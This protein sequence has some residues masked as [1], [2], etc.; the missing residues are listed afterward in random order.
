MEDINKSTLIGVVFDLSESHEPNGIRTID[1]IKN[2]LCQK[3]LNE[4][5]QTKVF[6]SHPD[7]K[8]A[9]KDQGQSTFF[10][11]AY[12]EPNNFSIDECFRNAITVVG[13]SQDSDK[14]V[15]LFTDRF[16]SSINYQY[17]KSFIYKELRDYDIKIRVVGI[18]NTYHK[19]HL[20]EI[21]NS[22]NS[23][24]VHLNN[25]NELVNH[26]IELIEGK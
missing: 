5:N 14:I 4:N 26:I 8:S 11:V 17:R 24:F 22:Y 7:L 12:K 6:V 18:G 1:T 9:P 16:Q 19:P 2:I 25:A 15:I 21:A 13:E 23:T 10:I 20:E 3:I